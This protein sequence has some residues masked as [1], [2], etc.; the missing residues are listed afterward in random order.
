[1]DRFLRVL[2]LLT[3]LCVSS[4]QSLLAI[5]VTRGPYL[6]IGGPN[7]IVIRWRTDTASESRVRYGSAPGSLMSVADNPVVTTE[8]EVTVNGLVA[9][10]TYYYSVG[11]TTAT[12]AGNDPSYLFVTFPTPG[13][14]VPTRVWVLGDPG[15]Q[16]SSQF[17]VRDAY[18]NF[19]GTRHTEFWLLL[20]DNAYE[21]G[22]DAEYQG[23]VFNTY[24]TMLRKSVIFPALGN[25]DTAQSTAYV[26][27][28]PYFDIFTLPKSGESGGTPSGTEHFYS[29]DFGNLHFI[30]LDSMT[31]DRSATGPMANWLQSDLNSTLRDWV[32][33]FWH[34][35]PYSKGSHDSDTE[36]ELVQ[37]R[38]NIVPILESHGVDLV[39]SGHSHNYERSYLIDGN[40]GVSTTFTD[41]NKKDGGGGRDPSYYL[42]P[43]GHPGR[44]GAVYTVAGSSGQTSGGALNHPAMFISLNL[45]GSMVLDFTGNRLDAQFLD[46]TGVVQDH[47]AILKG[48]VV[49]GVP[50]GLG[51]T[52]GDHRADLRWNVTSGATSYN[53][54]RATTSGG[55]YGTIGSGV[56]S[57]AYADTSA[58]NNTTYFYVISA[59]NTTGESGN[60][61]QVSAT[62][63]GSGPPAPPTSLVAHAAGK[64]K[65]NLTWTQSASPN[66]TQN[67]V[68]RSTSSSGPFSLIATIAPTTSY[69]NTGLTSGSTYYYFVTAVT[70]GGESTV[71][72]QASA[73]AR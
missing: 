21:S 46:S 29:F 51:A 33:A 58:L 62:P 13:T 54:K 61:S 27:T 43:A 63:Q 71:S 68:Y 15:T 60:S 25:H 41:A 12:L 24:P 3:V 30:C 48:N 67:K 4:T 18:Y 2:S 69:N 73:N 72:N 65:I 37:M 56:T 20:G 45:L 28:Y 32:I 36:I 23:A 42:K 66:V 1:M 26:D 19:T 55:P 49:P 6:Q 9:D 5:T 40:Y 35:P 47:F 17:A 38:Q 64:R 52:A 34:H 70:S 11:T 16:T 10:T 50:T 14:V 8:H 7:R 31:A 44:Q 22:T 53:V 39:L 57:T 59:I